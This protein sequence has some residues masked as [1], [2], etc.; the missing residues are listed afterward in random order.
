MEA[1]NKKYELGTEINQN[2]IL[3]NVPESEKAAITALL[4]EYGIKTEKQ[5][6]LLHAASMACPVLASMQNS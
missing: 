6:S 1:E 2:V 5:A 3:A 4:G